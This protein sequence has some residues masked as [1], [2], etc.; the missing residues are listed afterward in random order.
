MLKQRSIHLESE[1]ER[2]F[3]LI[4]NGEPVSEEHLINLSQKL[5]KV[6]NLMTFDETMDELIQKDS[7]SAWS[8]IK[9]IRPVFTRVAVENHYKGS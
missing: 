8:Y 6:G 4:Q 1:I 9:K 3:R 7:K 5:H 2:Q